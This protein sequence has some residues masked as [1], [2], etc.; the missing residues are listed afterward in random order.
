MGTQQDIVRVKKIAFRVLKLF[1]VFILIF[2]AVNIFVGQWLF[3]YD[4]S[5]K[6]QVIDSATGAPIEGALIAGVWELTHIIGG[7]LG[8]SAHATLVKSDRNGNFVIP[9]WVNF[10]PWK[11]L[12]TTKSQSPKTLI[13]KP[14]Y[15]VHVSHRLA[16]DGSYFDGT[17]TPEEK[18]LNNE[19]N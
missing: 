12:Y 19:N 14:G 15:M 18:Q 17:V 5:I 3:Y 4:K 16:R 6:G 13:I 11:L 10:K 9:S 1:A 7:G 8:G 2:T